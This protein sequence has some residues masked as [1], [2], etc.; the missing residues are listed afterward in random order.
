MDPNFLEMATH[1]DLQAP[2]DFIPSIKWGV[3]MVGTFCAA[4][5]K[6]YN[7]VSNAIGVSIGG[8][9][10]LNAMVIQNGAEYT[11]AEIIATVV[12]NN[13]IPFF[14]S[15]WTTQEDRKQGTVHSCHNKT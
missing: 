5:K 6:H 8:I 11:F 2:F 15:N 9:C 10:S 12:N 13:D 14:S 3:M 4:L 1:G 7:F